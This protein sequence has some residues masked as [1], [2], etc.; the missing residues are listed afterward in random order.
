MSENLAYGALFNAELY[1]C[2]LG[3]AKPDRE[4]FQSVLRVIDMPAESVLFI[5]DHSINVDAARAVGLQAAVFAPTD[6][7]DWTDAMCTLLEGY[8]LTVA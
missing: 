8:D 2:S 4:Y 5:D 7:Q 3:H 1:S 6:R